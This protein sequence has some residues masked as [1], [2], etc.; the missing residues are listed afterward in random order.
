MAIKQGT[1][2]VTT[3]ATPLNIFPDTDNV[4]GNHIAVTSA[5]AIQVGGPDVS[6]SNGFPVPAGTVMTFD[7]TPGDG[8]YGI[9]ASSATVNVIAT[10][11]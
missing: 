6:T 10:G 7:I 1:V 9:A 3:T 2:T 8:L 11:V 5:S 4:Y